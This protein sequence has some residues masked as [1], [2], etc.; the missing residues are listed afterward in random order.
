MVELVGNAIAGKQVAVS[1]GGANAAQS[2]SFV[3]DTS[4]DSVGFTC[5]HDTRASAAEYPAIL[6]CHRVSPFFGS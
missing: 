1:C 3:L 6:V 2:F 5:S 4:M